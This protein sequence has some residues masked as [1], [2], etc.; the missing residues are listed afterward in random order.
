MKKE[1][2]M[3]M[4]TFGIAAITVLTAS[5]QTFAD[6]GAQTWDVKANGKTI[7]T[8]E[9]E[10]AGRQ[11]LTELKTGYYKDLQDQLTAKE[12]QLLTIEPDN[13]TGTVQTVEQAVKSIEEKG[14]A[15]VSKS[16]IVKGNEAIPY[17]T[18]V[19]K[20][21]DMYQGESRVVRKGVDGTRYVVKDVRY[22][23]GEISSTKQ[24]SSSVVKEPVKEI[25]LKGTRDPAEK[26]RAELIAYAEK[27]LG[28]PYVWGGESLESGIDCS[29]FTM[30]VYEKFGYSLPHYSQAQAECG[31]E[32][33]S[34]A[35]AKAGDLIIYKG[36]VAI[37]R[38]DGTVIHAAPPEVTSGA[39]ADQSEILSIRRIIG[40]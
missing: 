13:G 39:P 1:I 34:L 18:E 37:Y 28:T 24:I 30:K 2:T 9:T 3:M 21:E 26:T 6:S 27:F 11:V 32:V 40:Q 25:V 20:T 5:S 7:A 16:E 36:H 10:A 38:G 15:T 17:S 4:C 35:E 22:T 14:S 19:R 12:D 29:G 23:N 31:T 33:A 8:V